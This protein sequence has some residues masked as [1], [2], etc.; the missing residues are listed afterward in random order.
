MKLI[1]TQENLSQGLN[2]VSHIASRNLNLP[3]LNNVLLK[4]EKGELKLI[5]TNLEIGIR[6]T[7]RG[8]IEAE[9]TFTIQA[10][11]LT[12]YVNL[13]PKQNIQIEKDESNLNIKCENYQTQIKGLEASEFPLLP[14]VEKSNKI[15]L[16][17]N[18]LKEF[19]NKVSFC[20]AIDES[21]PEI[22]GVLFKIK[23]KKLILV[24]TDSYRLA[25]KKIDLI[26]SDID[27]K[28]L[29]VPQKTIQELQR[30]LSFQT[31]GKINICFNENQ[32]LFEINNLELISRLIEGQYPDY[33]Q[34][35]PQSFK[36]KTKVKVSEFL[37][38]VKS[39]SLF[40][41]P[42]IN[43]VKI[44]VVP[45]KKEMVVISTNANLGEN[46][47]TI[48]IDVEGDDNEIVFNYRYLLDG[49]NNINDQLLTF[50]ITNNATPGIFRPTSD[51]S[52]L[53]IIMPIR[54]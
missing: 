26:E 5:T 8:K 16:N 40:C 7:V 28:Q 9:G 44:T 4:A 19:L 2:I 36:T 13:L 20:V 37:Q 1:C 25:E 29:I 32:I 18:D 21:R 23:D 38:A 39:A 54:Q 46:I 52:Y 43:D 49:L 27:N 33:E 22:S 6:L 3:I 48:K 15:S 35:I 45:A 14:E 10:K 42:G 50:E 12:D 41:K 24:A 30:V 31:D 47:T 11:L 17:I 51:E 53:Y 34:I